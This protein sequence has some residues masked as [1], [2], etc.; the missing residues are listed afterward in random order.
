LKGRYDRGA[1]A[2]DGH[3]GAARCGGLGEPQGM[4]PL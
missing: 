1:R 2:A 4:D 3:V